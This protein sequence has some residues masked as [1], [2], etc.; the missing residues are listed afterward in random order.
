MMTHILS[1]NRQEIINAL[2]EYARQFDRLAKLVKGGD[3]QDVERVFS[4]VRRNRQEMFP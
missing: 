1:T 2:E 4:Q 3:Q